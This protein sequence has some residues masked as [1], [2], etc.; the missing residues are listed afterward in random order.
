MQTGWYQENNKWYYLAENGKMVTGLYQVYHSTYYFDGS[1]VM[2]TGWI[3]LGDNWHYFDKSG[4]MLRNTV[5]PDG[6]YVDQEGDLERV[7]AKVS[8]T[9]ELI[10]IEES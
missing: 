6:Y 2:Q 3:K 4:A 1:G 10:P 9:T 7:T 5:T 8:T